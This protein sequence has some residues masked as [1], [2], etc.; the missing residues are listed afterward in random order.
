MGT[1]GSMGMG[2]VRAVLAAGTRKLST[3]TQGC[4]SWG[5]HLWRGG[6]DQCDSNVGTRNSCL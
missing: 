2:P 3:L 1:V 4:G 5:V 6:R